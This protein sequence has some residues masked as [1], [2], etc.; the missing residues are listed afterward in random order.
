[1]DN[2]VRLLITVQKSN[3]HKLYKI[4]LD[5]FYSSSVEQVLH[6]VEQVPDL[7]VKRQRVVKW[8]IEQATNYVRKQA[9]YITLQQLIEHINYHPTQLK[10]KLI[11]E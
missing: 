1:M 2:K 3:D 8:G 11:M 6:T 4:S 5:A 10:L 9:E 7:D